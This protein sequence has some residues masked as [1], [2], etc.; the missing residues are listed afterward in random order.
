MNKS[1]YDE[2]WENL[3]QFNHARKINWVEQLQTFYAAELQREQ[4]LMS[5]MYEKRK[6]KKRKHH[7]LPTPQQVV[8]PLEKTEETSNTAELPASSI[9]FSP[10]R[11][12]LGNSPLSRGLN[13]A[14]H[15]LVSYAKQTLG[16]SPALAPIVHGIRQACQQNV[17]LRNLAGLLPRPVLQPA[18]AGQPPALL[19]FGMPPAPLHPT[20]PEEFNQ[21]MQS[22]RATAPQHLRQPQPA[23]VLQRPE[24]MR[25]V[26]RQASREA[27]AIHV[28]NH[29]TQQLTHARTPELHRCMINDAC[30][31]LDHAGL[32]QFVDSLYSEPGLEQELNAA[33]HRM[34]LQQL[35]FNPRP[36]PVFQATPMM[37]YSAVGFGA[38]FHVPKRRQPDLLDIQQEQSLWRQLM[39]P[40]R[41]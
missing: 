14:A 40:F 27:V 31:V 4:D 26:I 18:A 30:R 24:H 21:H 6:H 9:D 38:L 22:M 13:Q 16:N 12:N 28:L 33:L 36:Q 23:E 8:K 19:G 3:H 34:Y 37:P 32:H 5:S 17:F 11:I 41:R 1:Q 35:D 39:T 29:M 15:A 7:P 25:D 20:A 2:E 10:I